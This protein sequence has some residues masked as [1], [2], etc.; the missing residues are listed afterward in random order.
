LQT[1]SGLTY[2]AAMKIDWQPLQTLIAANQRFVITSHIRPD[3][4][5]IGSEVGLASVLRQLG[6]DVRIV[7]V[8][9]TPPHLKFLDPDGEI[10]QLGPG[11][12]TDAVLA[13]DVHL[14]VD[15]SAWGQ[16][17]DIGRMMRESG[18]PRAVID[19]HVSADD[20]GRWSARTSRA[21]PP[22]R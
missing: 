21:R 7:N 11:P 22:G 18:Q 9:A 8:S 19:H 12:A 10:L 6:K 15:T 16:L 4:D 2:D 13:A 20:R 3:A 14:I 5:A 1:P 17:S